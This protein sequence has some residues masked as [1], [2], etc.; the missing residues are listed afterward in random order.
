M[1]FPFFSVYLISQVVCFGEAAVAELWEC[2]KHFA[3]EAS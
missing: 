3:S 1:K 2:V